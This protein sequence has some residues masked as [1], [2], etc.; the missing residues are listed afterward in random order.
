MICTNTAKEFHVFSTKLASFALVLLE[1]EKT[2]VVTSACYLAK[3]GNKKALESLRT[4]ANEGNRNAEEKL[5]D[6]KPVQC[7]IS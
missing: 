1:M 4:F 2:V 5:H 7:V 6:I 3:K